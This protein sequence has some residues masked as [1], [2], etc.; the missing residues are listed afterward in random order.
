MYSPSKGKR[1]GVKDNVKFYEIWSFK[2]AKSYKIQIG[3][4][5]QSLPII[6]KKRFSV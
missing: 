2:F 3:V 6:Y 1:C 5:C 4:I